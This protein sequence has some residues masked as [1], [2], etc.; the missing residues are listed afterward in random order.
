MRV[1]PSFIPEQDA[2]AVHDSRI[3]GNIV[4]ATSVIRADDGKEYEVLGIGAI[5][6]LPEYQRRGIGRR[7]IGMRRPSRSVRCKG[8]PYPA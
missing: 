1:S 5:A 2:V 4:D 7:I 6:V 3:V 8:V